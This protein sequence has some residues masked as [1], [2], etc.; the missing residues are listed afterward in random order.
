MRW[1]PLSLTLIWTC[2]MSAR[3]AALAGGPHG[4]VW[5]SLLNSCWTHQKKECA[6]ADHEAVPDYPPLKGS[7][8]R[9]PNGQGPQ[10]AAVWAPLEAFPAK[11]T[12]ILRRDRPV[13][14]SIPF[15]RH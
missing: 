10:V 13:D 14:T 6:D 12:S 5:F 4:A 15:S 8:F 9:I 1:T 7:R 2:M 3:N 11:A